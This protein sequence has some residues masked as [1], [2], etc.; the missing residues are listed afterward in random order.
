VISAENAA[1]PILMLHGDADPTVKY[2]FGVQSFDILKEA[3]ANVQMKTYKG[4]RHSINPIEL[5]DMVEFL[6]Q[7]L[8]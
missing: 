5:S 1:I 7:T 8:Q 4:L 3:G 2:R 6:M